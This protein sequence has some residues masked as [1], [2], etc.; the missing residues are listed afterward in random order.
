MGP[1]H[2]GRSQQCRKS[3]GP[4]GWWRCALRSGW[5]IISHKLLGYVSVAQDFNSMG[6][7]G[8]G[9]LTRSDDRLHVAPE[10]AYLLDQHRSNSI[11]LTGTTYLRASWTATTS[12]GTCLNEESKRPWSGKVPPVKQSIYKRIYSFPQARSGTSTSLVEA[13]II[14]S[15]YIRNRNPYDVRVKTAPVPSKGEIETGHGSKSA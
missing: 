1:R 5:Y 3:L 15:I 6:K 4:H 14:A 12:P 11:T 2:L 9:L 8:P 7:R 13:V 10:P